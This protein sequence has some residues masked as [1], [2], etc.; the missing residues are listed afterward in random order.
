MD[1]GWHDTQ[2]HPETGAFALVRTGAGL[3]DLV[4]EILRVTSAA[5]SARSVY[6]Y[7]L[8]SA[9]VPTDLS[10]TRRGFAALG[11]LSLESL[12]CLVEVVE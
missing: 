2:T 6:V 7:C 11:L 9:G 1:A 10:L 5:P 8:G 12:A 4:G 3:D